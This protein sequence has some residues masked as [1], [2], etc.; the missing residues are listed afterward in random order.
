MILRNVTWCDL[1]LV[2]GPGCHSTSGNDD[3]DDVDA[4]Q[5]GDNDAITPALGM[6]YG[7]GNGRVPE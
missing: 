6:I 7:L 1:V 3:D 5:G 2:P 4:D